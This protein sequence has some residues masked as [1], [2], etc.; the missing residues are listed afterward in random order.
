MVLSKTV[1]IEKVFAKCLKWVDHIQYAQ[2]K[3]KFMAIFW[4]NNVFR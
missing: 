4:F 2:Q 3:M 1:N